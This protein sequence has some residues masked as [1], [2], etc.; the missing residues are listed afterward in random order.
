MTDGS[1]PASGLAGPPRPSTFVQSLL[2]RI[3]SIRAEQAYLGAGLLFGLALVF[4]TPPYQVPD[5]ES[6][7]RRAYQIAEGRIISQKRGDFTGD[8]LPV[9]VEALYRRFKP[10][11]IHL[12]EK[13]TIADIRVA[14]DVASVR[15]EREFVVFS[16]T[17]IHPPLPY[18]PQALG[19]LL[20]RT[21]TTSLLPC[22][23]AG[24]ICNLLASTAL[25]WLSIRVSPVG[26]WAFAAFALTPRALSLAASLSS[27]A[28]TNALSFLLIAYVLSRALAPRGSISWREVAVTAGLGIAVG[29]AKQAYFFL[30]L[31]YLLV[32]IGDRAQRA[33]YW[34][35]FGVVMSATFMAVAC[36]SLVVREIYSPADLRFGINPREQLRLMAS[37]PGEFVL[38]IFRTL[39]FLP[40]YVEGYLGNLGMLDLRLGIVAEVC[41]LLLLMVICFVEFGPTAGITLGQAWVAGAVALAV[42]LSIMVIVHLTWDDLGSRDIS[43]QGRY[44]IPISPLLGIVLGRLSYFLPAAA[45]FASRLLPAVSMS[46]FVLLLT[47]TLFCVFDRYF[48]DN[49]AAATRRHCFR[50]DAFLAEGAKQKAREEFE[51]ALRHDPADEYAHFRLGELLEQA[52]PR[53]AADHYR[54]I[55]ERTP[56]N[57][58]TLYNLGNILIREGEYAAAVPYLQKAVRIDPNDAQARAGLGYALQWREIVERALPTMSG[59]ILKLATSVLVEKRFSASSGDGLFLKHQR[60]RVTDERGQPPINGIDFV[61]RVPPPGGE[62]IKLLQLDGS[63]DTTNKRRCFYACSTSLL[64]TKRI[65]IFPP[66][67]NALLIEDENISWRFQTTLKDLNAMELEQENLFRREHD[68]RFPL[69]ALPDE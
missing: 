67:A 31:C 43:I 42:T 44:F 15:D 22:L 12:E 25:V 62:E 23:Y 52:Q 14:A 29:L 66:P 60:G 36:W 68:L 5:E 53:A 38:A 59:T 16:N 32:P 37:N 9:A 40:H 65:L 56:D 7:F 46:G 45:R 20:A 27:E 19:V 61:W 2:Q 57:F 39:G 3:H 18:L 58:L 55:L 11:Q 13:A 63:P 28:L 34:T 47:W 10:M 54:A 24:R 30:P 50:G 35:G 49:E 1:R 8:E 41:Q 64:G 69:R 51:Q 48:V 6:H 4:L 17:A 33:R 26:K 21:A